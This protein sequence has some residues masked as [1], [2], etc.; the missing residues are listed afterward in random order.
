MITVLHNKIIKDKDNSTQRKIFTNT[1]N[2]FLSL[3]EIIV[4]KK[5]STCLIPL[6]SI[7][8]NRKPVIEKVFEIY[9]KIRK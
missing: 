4:L 8:Y 7:C 1:L 2:N 9:L 3:Y 5:K 6:V